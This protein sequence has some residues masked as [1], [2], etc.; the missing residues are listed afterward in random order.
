MA[1]CPKVITDFRQHKITPTL[2]G[3]RGFQQIVC[4]P[5]ATPV[6]TTTTTTKKPTIKPT[7]AGS[8]NKTYTTKSGQSK[9]FLGVYWNLHLFSTSFPLDCARYQEYVYEYVKFGALVDGGEVNKRK[10]DRCG[11]K[12]VSLI[13]GGEAAK[14]REFPHMVCKVF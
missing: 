3:W 9:F 8:V 13:V 6:T 10:V 14:P 4:C 11:H 1:N 7:T 12:V 2:C 5:G